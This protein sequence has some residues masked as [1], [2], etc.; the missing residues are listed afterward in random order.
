MNTCTSSQTNAQLA[1][2]ANFLL[3]RLMAIVH[4]NFPDSNTRMSA[5]QKIFV[6][7]VN[8]AEAYIKEILAKEKARMNRIANREFRRLRKD[9]ENTLKAT[10]ERDVF[11]AANIEPSFGPSLR[12]AEV[13]L[14]NRLG[15]VTIEEGVREDIMGIFKGILYSFT[16]ALSVE[17]SGPEGRNTRY[18][19]FIDGQNHLIEC[20]RLL[21]KHREDAYAENEDLVRSLCRYDE[22]NKLMIPYGDEER[23][24]WDKYS[25]KDDKFI[26]SPL[27]GPTALSMKVCISAPPF[28]GRPDADL[29][30]DPH[31]QRFWTRSRGKRQSRTRGMHQPSES[32]SKRRQKFTAVL[33]MPA[34]R[35]MTIHL[36]LTMENIPVST[37]PV[38]KLIT[39]RRVTMRQFHLQ[40]LRISFL[41]MI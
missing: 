14:R 9:H 40:R 8:G 25:A 5:I 39:I 17:E 30:L 29:E 24:P 12:N 16:Y 33:R 34:C 11:A 36:E 21:H 31:W 18:L 10:Y 1:T 7:Y 32:P 4:G 22:N 15:G 23:D 35:S 13:E 41:R 38:N 3:E 19:S 28:Q 26:L 2:K 27:D 20:L 6:E 37:L